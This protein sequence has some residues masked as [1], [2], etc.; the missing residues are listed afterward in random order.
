[1]DVPRGRGS[2][3]SIDA[4]NYPPTV[5]AQ[6]VLIRSNYGCRNVYV[7]YV[8]ELQKKLRVLQAMHPFETVAL[9]PPEES[10]GSRMDDP[11]SGSP[12]GR[13]QA[14]RGGSTVSYDRLSLYNARL[15][16]SVPS[17]YVSTVHVHAKE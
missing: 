17:M 7:M 9:A 15:Y 10:L 11:L 1:M 14:S 3:I 16:R 2:A 5:M 8:C 4:L 6:V 12:A 13:R